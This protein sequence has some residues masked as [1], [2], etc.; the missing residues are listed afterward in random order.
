MFWNVDSV[1]KGLTEI[2]NC[3]EE[4]LNELESLLNNFNSWEKNRLYYETVAGDWLEH[5]A[6]SVYAARTEIFDDGNLQ[7]LN[8]LIP[9]T[10]D[11]KAYSALQSN[12]SGLHEHLKTAIFHLLSGGSPK[13]FK[14]SADSVNVS[15]NK[16]R[17]WIEKLMRLISTRRPDVLMV[18]PY[19]KCGRID[20]FFA[21]VKW[22]RWLAWDD[23]FY[24]INFQVKLNAE[25]RLQRACSVS[26]VN[27]LVSLIKVLLP[28]HLPVALLE[29]LSTYRT[30]MVTMPL[31]RPKLLY[32]ANA[33]HGHLPFKILAA[34]WRE[35]GT[36]LIYHQHGGSYGLDKI[37]AIEEYEIRVSDKYFT[38]GWRKKGNKNVI[39]MTF[40]KLTIPFRKRRFILFV[41]DDFPIVVYRLHFH[42]MTD[43]IIKMKKETC[44]FLFLMRNQKNLFIR[45]QCKDYSGNYINMLHAAAPS[46]IFDNL[47][48][49]IYE[50]F[51]QSRLVVHN[52]LGTTYLETLAL[53]IPTV[54]F[55]DPNVYSFREEAKPFIDELERV[56]IIYRS[57][58]S[59]AVFL[60]SIIDDPEGWWMQDDLQN[61]RNAFV[62]NYANFS[63]N[64]KGE[65]EQV[66]RLIINENP[67]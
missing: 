5:F 52:Y 37:H 16:K 49:S 43:S 63:V 2:A 66:L 38:W 64:W 4:L 39:P 30:I 56:G 55:Y 14:F 47:S 58:K 6:H 61:V 54:C 22:R 32:S 36:K 23:L 59:A 12:Q 27:N 20:F 35:E 21:L 28:L 26:P 50:R 11:I 53:N 65:W 1:Y 7:Q 51:A 25:W 40:A 33:L 9:V 57:A 34:E 19:F 48:A 17:R 8:Y 60:A 41:L 44:E 10:P 31:F 24:Q 13:A 62:K 42:P 67:A 3:R 18:H 15:N 45:T 29:G 46:A